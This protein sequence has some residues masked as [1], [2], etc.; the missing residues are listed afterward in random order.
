MFVDD[1][2]EAIRRITEKGQI[3]EVYNIGTEFE[4]PNLH[5][6][7]IIHTEVAKLMGRYM[8]VPSKL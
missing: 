2:A 7:Q 8:E 5:V 3:G 6:T 4:M 1:C